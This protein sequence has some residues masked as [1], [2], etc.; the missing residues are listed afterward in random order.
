MYTILALTVL[1]LFMLWRSRQDGK[2][3]VEND[4]K[5]KVIQQNE[6]DISYISKQKDF[7][8]KLRNDSD[9]LE[10]VRRLTNPPPK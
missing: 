5:D 7:E 8:D 4:I 2:L 9:A 10:R 1:A 6:A 3:S